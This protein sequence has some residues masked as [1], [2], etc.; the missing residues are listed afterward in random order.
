MIMQA[1]LRLTAGMTSIFQRSTIEGNKLVLP[2]E[3]IDIATYKQLA[4]Y[5][6][7]HGGK[8]MWRHRGFLFEDGDARSLL[9]LP[10]AKPQPATTDPT[11]HLATA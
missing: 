2:P 3:P 10:P 8:F 4:A 6:A 7:Q 9:A 1:A 5:I 11:H